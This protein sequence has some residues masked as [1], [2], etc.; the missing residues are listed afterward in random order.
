MVNAVR[1]LKQSYRETQIVRDSSIVHFLRRNYLPLRL[2]IM[3]FIMSCLLTLHM[4]NP[5][6]G[7][8]C[9]VVLEKYMLSDDDGR[10][11]TAIGHLRD[12]SDLYITAFFAWYKI[13]NLLFCL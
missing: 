12:S 7:Q 11:P 2:A 3:K 13:L 5:K 9:S 1:P 4:L 6:F 8:D 10:Q